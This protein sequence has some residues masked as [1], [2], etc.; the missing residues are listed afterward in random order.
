MLLARKKDGRAEAERI[1]KKI[2][3]E[4]PSYIPALLAYSDMLKVEGRFADSIPIYR[5]ILD[6][7]CDYLPA[8]VDLSIALLKAGQAA[9]AAQLVDELLDANPR[10]PDIWMAKAQILDGSG[11]KQ[12]AAEARRNARTL[13]KQSSA[14][15][16][17]AAKSR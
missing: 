9:K 13:K 8:S 1:W 3:T 12:K 10:N 5:S 14:S 2:L 6:Y 17:A 11:E 7:R 4:Q 16:V 15:T